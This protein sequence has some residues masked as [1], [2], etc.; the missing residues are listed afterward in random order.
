M[1]STHLSFCSSYSTHS[2][3]YSAS[4]PWN[5]NKIITRFK[6]PKIRYNF[7]IPDL[8]FV[9]IS[10][11]LAYLCFTCS[12]RRDCIHTCT[13]QISTL[14]PV[15][16]STHCVFWQNLLRQREGKISAIQT[17]KTESFNRSFYLSIIVMFEVNCF[18]PTHV[19]LLRIVEGGC[20]S[21]V[22]VMCIIA[23]MK[24]LPNVDR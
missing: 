3:H 7:K 8:I 17:F 24:C 19:I 21:D 6:N 23:S 1:N 12:S 16:A 5:D 2:H 11:I 10:K 22:Y 4:F 15:R 20:E 18:L 14:W 9:A 13:K